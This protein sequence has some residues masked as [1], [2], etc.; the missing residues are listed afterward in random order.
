MSGAS[1]KQSKSQLS[2]SLNARRMKTDLKTSENVFLQSGSRSRSSS[3]ILPQKTA[4]NCETSKTAGNSAIRCDEVF[5]PSPL[6]SRFH[7][8][9]P[10]KSAAD[11]A[12]L[13]WPLHANRFS[14]AHFAE[15]CKASLFTGVCDG[16][17]ILSIFFFSIAENY[18]AR[19]KRKNH[20]LT[21]E[22]SDCCANIH[23][24]FHLQISTSRPSDAPT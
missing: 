8:P 5:S 23:S 9:L 10:K 14:L 20:K 4:K 22:L 12:R 1:A 21:D 19:G 16:N 7:R 6:K 13:I 17:G 18:F 15:S 11:I 2:P 3:P 24:N